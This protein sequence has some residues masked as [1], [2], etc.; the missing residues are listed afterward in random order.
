MREK[1][2]TSRNALFHRYLR[3]ATFLNFSEKFQLTDCSM[4]IE[5]PRLFSGT[6]TLERFM[7]T[8]VG[9]LYLHTDRSDRNAR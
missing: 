2:A 4:V 7:T 6:G 9:K 1:F 5:T 3:V 8:L